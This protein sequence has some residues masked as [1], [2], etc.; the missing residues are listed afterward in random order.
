MADR[1]NEVNG[2]DPVS[3]TDPYPLIPPGTYDVVCS[4][5]RLYWS[6]A[7]R[8][9]V[10]RLDCQLLDEPTP[11]CGFLNLGCE[12]APKAGRKSHYWRVWVMANG[13]QPNKRQ[14]LSRSVF[15]GKFFRVRVADVKRRYDNTEPSEAELYSTI[16]EWFACI[17]P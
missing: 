10:C 4:G 3:E 1:R 11:L 14:R 16:Q 13:A 5:T 12:Q 15:A 9:W 2:A 6:K 8:R 7:F 17:G